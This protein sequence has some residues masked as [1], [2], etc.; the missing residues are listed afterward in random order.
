MDR[1]KQIARVEA[2]RPIALRQA[3][4]ACRKG[5]TVCVAG[6]YTGF[7]EKIRLGA[8]TNKGLTMKTGQTHMMRFMKPL[9]DK[10][11]ADEIDPSFVVSHR[12]PIDQAPEMYKIFR[13][14]QENCTKVVLDPW[15]R[16]QKLPNQSNPEYLWT[17]PRVLV[18]DLP[19]LRNTP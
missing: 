19:A 8:F 10:I 11:E 14:K 9:L 6:V 7:D 3:I 17:T 2:D 5:G 16:A 12:V 4:Q 1:A 15:Q 13:D 18:L